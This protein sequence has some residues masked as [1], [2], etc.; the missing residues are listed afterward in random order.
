MPWTPTLLPLM[1]EPLGFVTE[2][3]RETQ[4]HNNIRAS[5]ADAA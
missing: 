5:N 1:C 4:T 2:E 3:P